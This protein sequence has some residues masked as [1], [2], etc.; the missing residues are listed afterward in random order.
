MT[1]IRISVSL[2]TSKERAEFR[3]LLKV[4]TALL[5]YVGQGFGACEQKI[6]LI[7]VATEVNDAIVWYGFHP[8]QKFFSRRFTKDRRPVSCQDW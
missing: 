3:W 7:E 1:L 4:I 2:N 6:I 8:G 5:Q